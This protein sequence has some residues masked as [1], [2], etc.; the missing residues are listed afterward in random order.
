MIDYMDDIRRFEEL[1]NYN[2]LVLFGAGGT[3]Y[4]TIKLMKKKNI[5]CLFDNDPSKWGKKIEGYMVYPPNKINDIV[6]A[7]TGIVI[8][9]ISYQYEI[10]LELINRYKIPQE[11]IY[12]YTNEYFEKNIYDVDKI[13]SNIKN[14]NKTLSLLEDDESK[15]YVKDSIIARLTRN[16]QYLKG[17]INIVNA[18]E[19]ADIVSLKTG[20]SIIDCGAYIGDTAELFLKKLDGNCKIYCIEPFKSS[21]DELNNYVRDNNINDKIKCLYNAVSN[22]KR[23]DI[24]RC[25]KDVS[26]MAAN[27][28]EKQGDVENIINVDTIDNLFNSTS[29]IDFIK[30]DIEGEEVNALKGSINI[31]KK[32]KPRMMISAY[33]LIEHIWE[34]PILIKE[35]NPNYKIYAGHQPNVTFEMEYYATI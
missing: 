16:A 25:N 17:N 33:H 4:T 34:I 24:V 28:R 7:K 2:K 30:M 19:Y 5:F 35:I 26:Y 27:I 8:S 9:A 23:T 31:I 10:A 18:Y 11:T 3:C 20:D 15:K 22:E 12:L 29:K 13:K 6:D 21:F 1:N 32:H 14:I